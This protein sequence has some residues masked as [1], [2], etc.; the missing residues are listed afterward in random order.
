MANF[1]IVQIKLGKISI[2]SVPNKFKNI[3]TEALNE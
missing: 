3:V 2:D 1:Y